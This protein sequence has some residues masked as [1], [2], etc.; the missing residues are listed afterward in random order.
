MHQRQ[1]GVINDA[2]LGAVAVGNDDLMAGGDQVH[3]S[4][5]SNLYGVCLLMKRAAQ[6]VAAQSDDDFL[7]HSVNTSKLNDSGGIRRRG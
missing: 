6:S 3:D 4:L 1:H 7:A 5:G 2:Y